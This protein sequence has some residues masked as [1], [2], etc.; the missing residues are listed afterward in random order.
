MVPR[1]RCR[2]QG[3]AEP[4]SPARDACGFLLR[5]FSLFFSASGEKLYHGPA[6]FHWAE[7]PKV[8]TPQRRGF[9]Q[10]AHSASNTVRAAVPVCSP[11]WGTSCDR[12]CASFSVQIVSPSRRKKLKRALRSVTRCQ[13]FDGG[14]FHAPLASSSGPTCSM[15]EKIKIAVHSRLIRASRFLLMPL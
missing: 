1:I 15:R 8:A 10:M 5:K 3:L 4:L 13:T 6:N 9:A 14:A 11:I 2:G 7:K 12:T